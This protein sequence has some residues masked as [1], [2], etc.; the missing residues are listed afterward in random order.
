[1]ASPLG[2]FFYRG[3]YFGGYDYLKSI[4]KNSENSN[5]NNTFLVNWSLAQI[6]TILTVTFTQPVDTVITKIQIQA[7]KNKSEHVYKSYMDCFKKVY[8]NYGYKGLYAGYSAS[9]ARAVLGSIV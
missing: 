9:A 6:S 1:M 4:S 8:Q 5:K 2:I 7:S 3:V